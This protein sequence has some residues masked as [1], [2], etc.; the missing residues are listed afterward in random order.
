MNPA[1]QV[2]LAFVLGLG[3]GIVAPSEGALHAL[4][5]LG[6]LW[7]NALR[8]PILPLI[9]MLTIA[10][11]TK[12][13]DTREAGALTGRAILTFLVLLLTFTAIMTTLAPLLLAGLPLDP[14]A[15]AALRASASVDAVNAGAQLTVS[16][17]V[18]SLVPTNPIKA[19][20]DGALLPLVLFAL[21]YGL[22]LTRLPEEVRR[23]QGEGAQGIADVLIV[24][25]RWVLLLAPVGVFALAYALGA[26]VGVPAASA[27]ARYLVVTSLA[28]IVGGAVLVGITLVVGR[29]APKPFLAALAPALVIAFSSRSSLAALPVLITGVREKLRLPEPVIG[30]VIPLAASLFKFN[31]AITWALGAVFVGALYGV[32]LHAAQL[33]TFGLGTVLLSLTTPGIPSGGFLVQAP[34]YLAVGLPAEGLGILIAIDLIPDLFKTAINVTGYAS[35]A[36]IVARGEV[37]A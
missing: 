34:L 35:S 14:A 17:W 27:V 7:I 8:M 9:V 15:T 24:M 37:K 23:R 19:A 13:R 10:G 36:V 28:I 22:A 2:F 18:T 4:E 30:V 6:T 21:L 25:I 32:P 26:K 31:A 12:A 5:P 16:S 20:A 29:I 11:I 1:L 3:A 33:V